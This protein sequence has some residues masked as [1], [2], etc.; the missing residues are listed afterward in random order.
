M[1][2][3]RRD[4]GVT[5]GGS[6]VSP[7]PGKRWAQRKKHSKF[8][9]RPTYTPGQEWDDAWAK[10]TAAARVDVPELPRRP[11]VRIEAMPD[12]S[13]SSS[14]SSVA[15][16]SAFH[17]KPPPPPE[18]T[19]QKAALIPGSIPLLRHRR[20]KVIG[21]GNQ[22]PSLRGFLVNQYP[23]LPPSKRL[24]SSRRR[25]GEPKRSSWKPAGRHK[26]MKKKTTLEKNKSEKHAKKKTEEER[27]G[28]STSRE[29]SASTDADKNASGV[30]SAPSENREGW[31]KNSA[32]YSSSLASKQPSVKSSTYAAAARIGATSLHT[33]TAISTQM[34]ISSAAS[35]SHNSMPVSAGGKK[36]FGPPLPLHV[37]MQDAAATQIRDMEKVK[38]NIRAILKKIAEMETKTKEARKKLG[39]NKDPTSMTAHQ[40]VELAKL[41]TKV[42]KE[43]K[44]YDS[45]EQLNDRIKLKIDEHRMLLINTK[46]AVLKMGKQISRLRDE[47]KKML[48]SNNLAEMNSRLE[49]KLDRAR[50][51]ESKQEERVR[52]KINRLKEEL[53]ELKKLNSKMK[54]AP[55]LNSGPRSTLEM[56]YEA[57]NAAAQAA[58]EDVTSDESSSSS[59]GI[60]ASDSWSSGESEDESGSAPV[61]DSSKRDKAR[62]IGN[63]RRRRNRNT[64]K[65]KKALQQP[66]SE[67]ISKLNYA[68]QTLAAAETLVRQKLSPVAIRKMGA[69]AKYA[70][71]IETGAFTVKDK[72]Q[73]M[74]KTAKHNWK[75]AKFLFRK[76]KKIEAEELNVKGKW[77]LCFA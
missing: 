5:E 29:V 61:S 40:R 58:T 70:H 67:Q 77:S 55:T 42:E 28:Q 30:S 15:N 35:N 66:N 39:V 24:P 10:M 1:T 11:P 34:N 21:D 51:K 12:T 31:S 62:H 56:Y 25:D 13:S 75:I 64:L 4:S 41:A 59:S 32:Q 54:R 53:F 68:E 36:T 44:D 18:A 65:K 7:I 8:L 6:K 3:A 73:L 38:N 50:A 52:Q 2:T 16:S 45:L 20:F 27:I 23:N 72:K 60:S 74:R 71:E 43:T 69:F 49:R 14:S 46:N 17:A 76:R 57:A 22:T 9:V 33:A 37:V 48:S 47:V 63:R 19:G 26:K